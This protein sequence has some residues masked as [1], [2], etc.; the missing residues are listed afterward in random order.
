[1]PRLFQDHYLGFFNT[2]Y[3]IIAGDEQ[4]IDKLPLNKICSCGH[5]CGQS[6][7]LTSDKAVKYWN[8]KHIGFSQKKLD[9]AWLCCDEVWFGYAGFL[10]WVLINPNI[11]HGKFQKVF[12]FG[13]KKTHSDYNIPFFAYISIFCYGSE[14]LFIW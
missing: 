2:F 10:F 7:Q 3:M 14:Y 1:M 9:W 4:Y 12:T 13:E 8:L 6:S 11:E 5:S